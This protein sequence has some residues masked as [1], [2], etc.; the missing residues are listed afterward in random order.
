GELAA[1]TDYVGAIALSASSIN[2][3]KNSDKT[4]RF[5]DGAIDEVAI[6]NRAL[7]DGEIAQLAK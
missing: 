4:N 5:Y 7:T 3:G 2:I 6:Y 1:V